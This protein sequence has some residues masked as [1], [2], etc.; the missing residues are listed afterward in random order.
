LKSNDFNL[1]LLQNIE[2]FN[3][4]TIKPNPPEKTLAFSGGFGLDEA[5]FFRK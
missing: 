3:Q 2:L 1:R 5:T 4:N